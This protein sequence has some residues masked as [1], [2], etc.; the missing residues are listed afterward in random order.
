M[1]GERIP[2]TESRWISLKKSSGS[3]A[4]VIDI[5]SSALEMC[6][7]QLKKDR[8]EILDRLDHPLRLGHEVFHDGKISFESIRELSRLL[9]G[10][11]EIMT[12]YG[13]SQYQVV[14][15]TAL[16]EAENRD[17]VLDQLKIQN[18]MT[19]RVLEEEQEKT[20]I[21]AEIL[22]ANPAQRRENTL[23]SHIGSGSLGL[24]LHSGEHMTFS[25]NIPIGPLKLHDLLG[26]LLGDARLFHM[27]V[28]EYLSTMIRRLPIPR[29]EGGIQNLMLTGNEVRLIARACGSE[30]QDGLYLLRPN[31]LNE[32][33]G[34]IHAMQPEKIGDMFG[35]TEESAELLYSALIIYI[36]LVRLTD[37]EHIYAPKI[38]L[39]DG[40]LRQ[41]LLPKA[42]T[43]YEDHVAANALS[44]ARVLAERY[45]CALSHADQVR[46]FACAVFDKTRAIHGLGKRARSLL[47][48]AAT[49]SDCGYFV[50]SNIPAAAAFEMLKNTGIYG[51]TSGEM[52]MVAAAVAFGRQ[53][54]P[55][56][57]SLTQ[58]GL[59]QT[60][61]LVISKLGAILRLA[62]SLDRSQTQKLS[63]IRVK[64]EREQL[65][66]IGES[67]ESLCLEK[68]AFD[69]N[70][71]YFE[72]VFGVRPCLKIKAVLPGAF[73]REGRA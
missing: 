50:N 9:C 37:A 44:C 35:I 54:G 31:A 15:T 59:D 39:W 16:R 4:A 53:D 43:E 64:L 62:D 73:G 5:G 70:A 8:V 38:E 45:Q 7:A 27:A 10:Y 20:L 58:A 12:E 67:A 69:R 48:V 29:V 49:L 32:L 36:Y 2:T 46:A 55:D 65:L 22:R 25:Q 26:E 28:E 3:V 71:V 21:Y 51:L 61:Q 63:G 40:M 41:L 57:F 1:R 19:V 66:L 72:E 60:K 6:V 18:D 34:R 52:L 30:E 14:A 68:W 11:T 13:V 24:A 33:F 23:I 17:Y 47:E 56:R 42:K